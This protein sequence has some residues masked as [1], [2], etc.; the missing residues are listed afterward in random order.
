MGKSYKGFH[1]HSLMDKFS[2]PKPFI[3]SRRFQFLG[4]ISLFIDGVK[5]S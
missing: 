5:I 2:D 3:I 4:K 1:A